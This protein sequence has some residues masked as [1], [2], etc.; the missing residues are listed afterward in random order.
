MPLY[1][2]FTVTFEILCFCIGLALLWRDKSLF[3]RLAI[4]FLFVTCVTEGFGI[5]LAEKYHNNLTLYNYFYLLEQGF[6]SYTMYCCFKPYIDPKLLI[7]SGSILLA[8]S[9]I[10]FFL[11]YT[12][13]DFNSLSQNVESILFV[14]YSLL[15][16]YLFLKDKK[17]VNI[18]DHPEFWWVTGILFFYFGSVIFNLFYRSITLKLFN[19]SIYYYL[20]T[21]LNLIL[22]S[23]WTYSFIC[24]AR[25]Q[26]LQS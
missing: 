7:I 19:R 22:Y 20:T 14:I 3:W 6:I 2:P 24:R 21:V 10:Y 25:Q 1:F 17:Y 26:K 4:V 8:L 13:M 5:Y 9:D 23:L 15:Y 11:G 18:S 16:F 12:G